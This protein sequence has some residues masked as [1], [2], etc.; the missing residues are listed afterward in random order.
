LTSEEEI[1]KDKEGHRNDVC[2]A[3][4]ASRKTNKS[5]EVYESIR[6]ITGKFTSKT[7]VIKGKDGKMIADAAKVKNRWK[8]LRG[9]IMTRIQ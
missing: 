2:K 1:K 5:R 7:S 6:K 8:D 9:C 3:I 4:E